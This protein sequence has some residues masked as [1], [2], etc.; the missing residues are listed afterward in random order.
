VQLGLV[1]LAEEV[2]GASVGLLPIAGNGYQ[3][4]VTWTTPGVASASAGAKLGVGPLYTLL[5]IGYNQVDGE[6]RLVPTAGLGVQWELGPVQLSLDA[7]AQGSH[8]VGEGEGDA[9]A[10]ASAADAGA[11][12]EQDDGDFFVSAR[13]L[14]GFRLQPWLRVFGG[15]AVV[16][17]PHD[18]T[19]NRDVKLRG[20]AGIEVF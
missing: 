1:N 3:R 7:L 11:D 20:V 14:L 2:D 4:F 15:P 13:P 18:T 6:D 19:W 10:G 16:S 8:V 9:D 5:G 12:G 17:G